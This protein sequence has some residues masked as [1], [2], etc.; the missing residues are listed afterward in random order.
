MT[1]YGKMM[2]S[3]ISVKYPKEMNYQAKIFIKYF[4]IAA[5][6]ESGIRDAKRALKEI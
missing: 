4:L 1:K 3:G 2:I 6:A 5:F